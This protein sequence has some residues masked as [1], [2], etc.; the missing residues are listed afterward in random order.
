MAPD[1]DFSGWTRLD[2]LS[3]SPSHVGLG[4]CYPSESLQIYLCNTTQD[5]LF[6]SCWRHSDSPRLLV[7]RSLKICRIDSMKFISETSIVH[8]STIHQI[9]L[10]YIMAIM[11]HGDPDLSCHVDIHGLRQQSLTVLA[12]LDGRHRLEP[13]RNDAAGMTLMVRMWDSRGKGKNYHYISLLVS[14][15]ANYF[16]IQGRAWKETLSILV[17]YLDKWC[18]AARLIS[19]HPPVGTVGAGSMIPRPSKYIQYRK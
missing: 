10:Y 6:D 15:F 11:V 3:R 19:T 7:L 9:V 17:A 1:R 18:H 2:A 5:N 13:G 4:C 16:P 14:T 12:V 8:H